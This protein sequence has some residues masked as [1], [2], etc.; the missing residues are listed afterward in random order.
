[1]VRSKPRNKPGVKP[2]KK[3]PQEEYEELKKKLENFNLKDI[4]NSKSG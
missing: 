3:T 4:T 1:M 2:V